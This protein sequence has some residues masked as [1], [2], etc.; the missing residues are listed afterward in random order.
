[1]SPLAK[2]T[3]GAR[4]ERL[5]RSL[6]PGEAVKITTHMLLDVE[7][8]ANPL[9][10]QTP[11]YLVKWFRSRMPF[12]CTVTPNLPSSFADQWTFYRPLSR[13]PRRASNG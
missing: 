8:P 5:L 7:V 6:Q 4:M 12:Y 3:S 10:C 13:S 9:D 11:E 2:Y 1:M